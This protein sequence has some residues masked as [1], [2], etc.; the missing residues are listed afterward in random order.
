MSR[1]VVDLLILV[2][3]CVLIT[4]SIV[5]FLLC[6]LCVCVFFLCFFFFSSRSRHTRCALVT[7]VQTCA[8]PIST[9]GVRIMPDELMR[10]LSWAVLST[11]IAGGGAAGTTEPA[12]T[13]VQ[14]SDF[15][16]PGSLSNSWADFDGD[17]DLDFA[18]SI[19][20][21]EGS[22][23]RRVG[24]SVSVRVEIGGG[25]TIKK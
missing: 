12:F 18:V 3:F 5:F 20:T 15:S 25:R 4:L 23:E 10:I 24:K 16:V 8:R 22:E 14:P 13:P 19:K 17:G 1:V 21:G 2:M 11:G 9:T 6:V 7:G